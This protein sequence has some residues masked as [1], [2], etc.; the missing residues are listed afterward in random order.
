MFVEE[1]WVTIAGGGHLAI[2]TR[3]ECRDAIGLPA[4]WSARSVTIVNA[5][6]TLIGIMAMAQGGGDHISLPPTIRLVNLG[7]EAC[8]PALVS[9]LAKPGLRLINSYGPS[10]SEFVE[11]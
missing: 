6:P 1:M 3:E 8:P 4:V 2:G 9:R 10:E 11:P 5:V 7:G